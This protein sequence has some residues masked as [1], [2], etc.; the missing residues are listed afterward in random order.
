[1]TCY[2][3][4][5]TSFASIL[6]VVMRKKLDDTSVL[7]LETS[8]YKTALS[9]VSDNA[10][11][12]RYPSN[13]PIVSVVG[14]VTVLTVLE[15]EIYRRKITRRMNW[16]QR[17]S[18]SGGLYM[19]RRWLHITEEFKSRGWTAEVSGA[20]PREWKSR[21]R[22]VTGCFHYFSLSMGVPRFPSRS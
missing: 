7:L 14:V 16:L 15:S 13:L 8:C 1:M 12:L 9:L 2:L 22:L 6:M 3:R 17:C 19:R 18:G 5:R 20:S 10:R 4:T 21:T 11:F